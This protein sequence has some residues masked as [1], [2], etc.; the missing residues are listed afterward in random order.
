MLSKRT[1]SKTTTRKSIFKK[2]H[3]PYNSLSCQCHT[4]VYLLS[5]LFFLLLGFMLK[6]FDLKLGVVL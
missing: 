1:S 3:A 5:S 6:L 2:E 4:Y